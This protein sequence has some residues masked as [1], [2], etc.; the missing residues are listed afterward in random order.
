[1]LKNAGSSRDKA[2]VAM[3]DGM[4]IGHWIGKNV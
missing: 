3:N 1:M 2:Y 4:S